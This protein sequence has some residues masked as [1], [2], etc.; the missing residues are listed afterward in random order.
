M[1]VR[2]LKLGFS[3]KCAVVAAFRSL[4]RPVN[5]SFPGGRRLVGPRTGGDELKNLLLCGKSSLHSTITQ[6]VVQSLNWLSCFFFYNVVI[7]HSVFAIFFIDADAMN[8][9]ICYVFKCV[10]YCEFYCTAVKLYFGRET[11]VFLKLLVYRPDNPTSI[12]GKYTNYFFSATP[13]PALESTV[14]F[15]QWVQ[16]WRFL[17]NKA[18]GAYG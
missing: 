1:A 9:Y 17:G 12:S 10:N 11:V 14:S 16:V 3:W 2:I 15:L 13:K 8:Y 18:V 7:R 5:L 6:R 4:Y